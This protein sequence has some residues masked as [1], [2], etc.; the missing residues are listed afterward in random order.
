MHSL[1][2]RRLDRWRLKCEIVSCLVL[3]I[4]E[5]FEEG[6][7]R[8]NVRPRFPGSLPNCY[9][10]CNLD[11]F[12]LAEQ[13]ASKLSSALSS[14]PSDARAAL[15]ESTELIGLNTPRSR[16]LDCGRQDSS[17]RDSFRRGYCIEPPETSIS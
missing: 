7:P 3:G 14:I 2:E 1:E 4:H 10:A 12:A 15:S 17:S 16:I 9:G 8:S 6:V 5:R 13:L 11:L